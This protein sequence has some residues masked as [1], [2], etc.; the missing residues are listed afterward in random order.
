MTIKYVYT[1]RTLRSFNITKYQDAL[2]KLNL[3]ELHMHDFWSKHNIVLD[4]GFGSGEIT[5]H[6][7]CN[8][9]EINILACDPFLS[10]IICLSNYFAVKHDRLFV[11]PNVVEH[12]INLIP[13]LAIHEV[14]IIHPDPWPKRKHHKRR[15]IQDTFVQDLYRI[16]NTVIICT[17]VEEYFIHIHDCMSKM[18]VLHQLTHENLYN[19]PNSKYRNKALCKT[20]YMIWK[21]Q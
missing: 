18:F 13:D 4:I 20:Y 1:K 3:F 17:D 7:L 6:R 15:L 16:T 14:M 5:Y 8:E 2:S 9:P 21:R 11:Y 19:W 10:G 12:I